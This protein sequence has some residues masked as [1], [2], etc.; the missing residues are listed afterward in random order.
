MKYDEF[1]EMCCRAW[2]EKINY[3]CINLTKKTEVIVVFL[4]KGKTYVLNAIPKVKLFSFL[5]VVPF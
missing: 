2:N 4:T 5:N 3:L 1:Q